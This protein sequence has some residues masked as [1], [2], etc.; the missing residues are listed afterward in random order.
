MQQAGYAGGPGVGI[1]GT[2]SSGNAP[3]Q[4]AYPFHSIISD[5]YYDDFSDSYDNYSRSGPSNNDAPHNDQAVFGN[6]NLMRGAGRGQGIQKQKP[7]NPQSVSKTL[8]N[9]FS[10]E[11][12][13]LLKF[14]AVS[15]GGNTKLPKG[16]EPM[17][18]RPNNLPKQS[19]AEIK[20][21]NQLVE[22]NRRE[23]MLK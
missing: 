15:K 3:P 21:V 6:A 18:Y 8:G 12:K 11:W 22:E 20:K 14:M 19:E 17:S 10:Q 16:M 9:V 23:Y 13:E 5:E 1:P 2:H 7:Q 4:F